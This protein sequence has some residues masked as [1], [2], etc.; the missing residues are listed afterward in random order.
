[1]IEVVLIPMVIFV[2]GVVLGWIARGHVH[3]ITDKAVAA[4]KDAADKV[5]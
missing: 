1:M 3:E 4:V 2:V 5:S